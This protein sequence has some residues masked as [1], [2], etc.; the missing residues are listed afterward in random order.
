VP[1]LEK[2]LLRVGAALQE[3]CASL[4]LVGVTLHRICA[5][6]LLSGT[7]LLETLEQATARTAERHWL[8]GLLV[9]SGLPEP[10]SPFSKALESKVSGACFRIIPT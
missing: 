3:I 10:R 6:L 2:A 4:L 5:S 8:V 7:D 1:A 9:S